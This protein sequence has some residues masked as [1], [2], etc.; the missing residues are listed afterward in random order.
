LGRALAREA[1]ELEF[2]K[3]GGRKRRVARLRYPRPV[4]VDGV[5]NV[6]GENAD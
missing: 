4:W 6:L 1:I 2:A 3:G 5:A